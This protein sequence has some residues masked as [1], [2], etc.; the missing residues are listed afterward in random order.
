MLAYF[1]AASELCDKCEG[2]RQIMGHDGLVPTVFCVRVMIVVDFL[3]QGGAVYITMGTGTFT[4]CTFTSN[5]A[6]SC[7]SLR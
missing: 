5:T 2:L 7:R 1:F 3:L 6:V 4:D